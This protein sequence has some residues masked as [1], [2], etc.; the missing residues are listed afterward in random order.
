M[1]RA[2][3]NWSRRRGPRLRQALHDV[4]VDVGQAVVAVLEAEGE[5]GVV[6]AKEAPQPGSTWIASPFRTSLVY[7]L[8]RSDRS[9][10]HAGVKSDA[11]KLV[12]KPWAVF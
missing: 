3:I 4:T 10:Q 12:A 11:L 1:Q 6:E 9:C 2:P 8:D 7:G 5:A